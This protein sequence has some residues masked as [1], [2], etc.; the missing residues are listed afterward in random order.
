[1]NFTLKNYVKLLNIAKENFKFI[2]FEENFDVNEKVILWRHDV[3]FSP[4]KALVMAEQEFELGIKAYYFFQVNSLY[5]NVLEKE[6]SKIIKEIFLMGHYIGFHFDVDVDTFN[7]MKFFDDKIKFE[8]GILENIINS[9]INVFSLHNP[10]TIKNIKFDDSRHFGLINASSPKLLKCFKYCSDSNGFWRF[11][12]LESLLTDH[13]IKKLYVL[14]HPIWWQEKEVKPRKKI[15]NLMTERST[16]LIN[17]YDHLLK[18]NNRKN[19]K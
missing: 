10:T 15:V 6:T 7:E 18:I 17:K 1:M 4:Q 9:K 14:T 13:N 19:I 5:Y 12:S 8:I 2:K 16:Y 3:D 11:D